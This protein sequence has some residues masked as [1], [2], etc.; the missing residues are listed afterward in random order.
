MKKNLRAE[1]NYV[2]PIVILLLAAGIWA[3]TQF[4]PAFYQKAQLSTDLSGILVANRRVPAEEVALKIFEHFQ[5]SADL[6]VK[7]EDVVYT[8]REDNPNL[9]SAKVKYRRLIHIPF[10]KEPYRLG[11]SIESEQDF[12]VM[13]T[14]N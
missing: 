11:L 13:N 3:G 9:V 14:L 4:I 1:F 5:K 6:E 8:V 10:Q 7:P 12:T 2:T